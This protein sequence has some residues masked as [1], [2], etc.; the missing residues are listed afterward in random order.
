VT[1]N[2]ETGRS[3]APPS[4]RIPIEEYL[5]QVKELAQRNG[6]AVEHYATIGEVSLPVLTRDLDKHK[7]LYLSS[8]AHG[9]EPAGP[10]AIAE[11]LRAGSF[12]HDFGW[13][14]FPALNPTGLQVGRRETAHGIDLN[15]DYRLLRAPE[16]AAHQE[17]LSRANH[18]YLA[19]L[20]LHEDWEAEGAYLYEHNRENLQNPGAALLKALDEIVGLDPSDEIDDW[21]T[22]GVGLIHPPSDPNLREFWPE[23]I[24]LLK[25]HSSI[26]YTVETPSERPLGDRVKA[27]VRCIEVFGESAAWC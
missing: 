19:V 14:I 17:W 4:E 9:D 27:V 26:S 2:R 21:P 7:L 25:H 18:T 13:V 11:A 5:E 12:S 20:G 23:Q 16:S 6:F 1:S 3:D 10:L 22:T 8:G 15:R 24:Y